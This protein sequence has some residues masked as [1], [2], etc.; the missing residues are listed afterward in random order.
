MS[1]RDDDRVLTMNSAPS[2]AA[3]VWLVVSPGIPAYAEQACLVRGRPQFDSIGILHS[4]CL[5]GR[6]ITVMQ[7]P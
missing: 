3:G 2:K 1:V 6:A 7:R 5:N 4:L